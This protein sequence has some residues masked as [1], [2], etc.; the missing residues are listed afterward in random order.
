MCVIEMIEMTVVTAIYVAYISVTIIIQIILSPALLI[1]LPPKHQIPCI[2]MDG[3][4]YHHHR[5]IC[6]RYHRE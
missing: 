6:H 4:H 1:K 2:V 5:W 3:E